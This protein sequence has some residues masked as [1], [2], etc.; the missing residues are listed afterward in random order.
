MYLEDLEHICSRASL[1]LVQSSYALASWLRSPLHPVLDL[2]TAELGSAVLPR[3]DLPAVAS[4]QC[5]QC[6][7]LLCLAPPAATLLPLQSTRPALLQGFRG[8]K[9]ALCL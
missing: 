7:S 1:D 5:Q 2:G 8:N 4:H 6:N 9:Q 3:E